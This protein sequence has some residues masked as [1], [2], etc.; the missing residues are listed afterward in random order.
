MH[1]Y[2]LEILARPGHN[3]WPSTE[4]GFQ[5]GQSRRCV[6][7]KWQEGLTNQNTSQVIDFKIRGGGRAGYI[8]FTNIFLVTWLYGYMVIWSGVNCTW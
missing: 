4:V 2:A 8:Y 1:T 7:S 5:S 3:I 6:S